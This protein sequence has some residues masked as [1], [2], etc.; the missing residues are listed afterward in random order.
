VVATIEAKTTL[1]NTESFLDACNTVCE[2]KHKEIGVAS[3][4]LYAYEGLTL[5]RSECPEE[6]R[7][8]CSRL[9]TVYL[10]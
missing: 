1:D 10:R 9:L 5:E 7:Q 3:C 6:L 4:G 2:E 8:A